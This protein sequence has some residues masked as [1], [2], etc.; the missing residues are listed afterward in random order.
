[1]ASCCLGYSE[2]ICTICTGLAIFELNWQ[3]DFLQSYPVGCKWWVVLP[4]MST[5]RFLHG[6]IMLL[7]NGNQLLLLLLNLFFRWRSTSVYQIRDA[8]KTQRHDTNLSG[9]QQSQESAAK[10]DQLS[11]AKWSGIG[12]PY[13]C[14][15][16][17]VGAHRRSTQPTD[18][19][20][21]I[22]HNSN[23]DCC[24]CAF[25]VHKTRHNASR[26]WQQP[27]AREFSTCNCQQKFYLHAKLAKLRSGTSLIF[28]F[29]LLGFGRVSLVYLLGITKDTTYL[30][31][32]LR[33][34]FPHFAGH[35]TKESF[36][37]ATF[38]LCRDRGSH[39]NLFAAGLFALLLLLSNHW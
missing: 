6:H 24:S 35:R 21:T 14:Q 20:Q 30:Q 34:T 1:M 4:Q 25:L 12:K 26:L 37:P 32:Y 27:D 13:N 19:E 33:W 18:S 16:A 3:Q 31:N 22:I 9:P 39:G 17:T 36:T 29:S 38:H 28:T 15:Y 23:M 2:A 10:Q 7:E 5:A 11:G 8:V